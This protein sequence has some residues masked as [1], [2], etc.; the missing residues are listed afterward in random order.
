MSNLLPANATQLERAVDTVIARIDDIPAPLAD[1]WNP[2]TCPADLLPWLAW[3]M[4]VE[5]WQPYWTD[6]IKR[7]VVRE[8][9]QVHR[10]KG[11]RA[12]VDR[13]LAAVGARAEIREWWQMDPPGQ[14]HTFEIDVYTGQMPT[15]PDEPLLGEVATKRMA[16]L[17]ESVKP[18]RSHYT[19]QVGASYTAGLAT[20]GA[21]R[22]PMNVV[23]TRCTQVP[24]RTL[25]AASQWQ[26]G[27]ALSRPGV[28]AVAR[29]TQQPNR[30][31]AA[32]S[33]WQRA[34]ALRR[35]AV[36]CT[37]VLRNP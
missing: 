8:S 25:A 36:V 33:Q 6:D 15:G 26:R 2:A 35:P 12:A 9:I 31:L 21:L 10:A 1:L 32:T 11:T 7:A 3:A 30:S 28:L 37:A 22:R 13:L 34:A 4:S 29:A 24:E 19:L 18:A 5:D 27:A 16:D 23:A 17:I 20:G 14:P